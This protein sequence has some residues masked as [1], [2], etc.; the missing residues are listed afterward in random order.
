MP[1]CRLRRLRL[2]E[3]D[4]DLIAPV[5]NRRVR[6]KCRPISRDHEVAAFT[7]DSA[8]LARIFSVACCCSRTS[9]LVCGLA[10][11]TRPKPSAQPTLTETNKLRLERQRRP[12]SKLEVG[13]RC[14]RTVSNTT[15]PDD[16]DSR[17]SAVWRQPSPSGE[18][19]HNY[20]FRGHQ[21]WCKVTRRTESPATLPR[22]SLVKAEH[23]RGRYSACWR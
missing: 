15:Q 21:P 18:Q 14:R 4:A 12:M 3:R 7:I 2:A 8:A 6:L 22:K 9:Y 16:D 5:S 1:A 13:C 17:C 20:L 19:H 11:S 23:F 10:I